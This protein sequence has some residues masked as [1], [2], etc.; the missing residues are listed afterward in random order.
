MT[1][2]PDDTTDTATE[3]PD[4]RSVPPDA[5]TVAFN[6][7]ALA[8]DPREF[9]KK[10][11]GLHRALTAVDEGMARLA[12]DRA[13]HD[14]AIAAERAELAA[15]RD[16]LMKRRVDV[17]QAEASLAERREYIIKK[18]AAWKNLGEP[19]EV[20]RG[21]QS[22]QYSPLEK[23]R[24]AH[25][26]EPI[27]TEPGP[28]DAGDAVTPRTVVVGREGTTLAQTIEAPAPAAARARPSRRGAAH[29]E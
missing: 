29:A 10:L 25:R 18:E 27:A 28:P 14:R 19:D 12:A 26:G 13:E 16:A 3:Q 8:A 17:H 15:E 22:P 20:I 6:L 24:R 23:A 11:Q 21:F 4:H 9:K 5:F 7:I 1:D 2:L